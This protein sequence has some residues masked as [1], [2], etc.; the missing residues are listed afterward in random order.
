MN[1]VQKSAKCINKIKFIFSGMLVIGL[2][3]IDLG[4]QKQVWSKNALE[5]ELGLINSETDNFI[6]LTV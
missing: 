1:L 5:K 2:Q 3:G 6:A 4:K